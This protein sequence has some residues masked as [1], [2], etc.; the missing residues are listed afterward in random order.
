ME[1]DTDSLKEWVEY[2]A[3]HTQGIDELLEM[4]ETDDRL[5]WVTEH[6]NFDSFAGL[7]EC[8]AIS[9]EIAELYDKIDEIAECSPSELATRYDI[10]DTDQAIEEAHTEIEKLE[11]NIEAKKDEYESCFREYFSKFY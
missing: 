3:R 10:D 9:E 4:V 1:Q 7:D 8:H 11:S 2:H 5:N 6:P